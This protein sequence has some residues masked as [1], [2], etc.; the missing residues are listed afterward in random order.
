VFAHSLDESELRRFYERGFP[1]VLLHQS[2][3][4]GLQIPSVTFENKQGAQS[5]VAHLLQCGRRRIVHLRG[6]EENEDAYWRELGYRAALAAHNLPVEAEL[7]VLGDFD[8]VVAE[9]A[10]SHLL[11]AGIPFDGIFAGDD[12]SARGALLALQEAGVRV[13][14][15]V[16]VVGFDDASYA[17]YL[18]PALTTVR[19]P[20]ELSG[21]QAAAQLIHLIRGEPAEPLVLLPTELIV[22]ES[23]GVVED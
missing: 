19:A 17:R 1:L 11:A 20:I 22:R 2:S 9:T 16:A 14:D 15:D 18:T 7:V 23:C 21:R 13:P 3:P 6:P 4:E 5:A 12:E 8:D 10:V